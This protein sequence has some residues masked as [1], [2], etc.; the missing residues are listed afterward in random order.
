[1][2]TDPVCGMRISPEETKGKSDYKGRTYHFCSTGCK[3]TFDAHP[4]RY[5]HQAEG[6]REESL[7]GE[8]R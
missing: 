5:A 2:D 6:T 3:E 1:M 8:R 7:T 4:E